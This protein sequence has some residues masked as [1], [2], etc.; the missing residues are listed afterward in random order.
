MT[1]FLNVAPGK[2]ATDI[3][4]LSRSSGGNRFDFSFTQYIYCIF[5]FIISFF[6]NIKNIKYRIKIVYCIRISKMI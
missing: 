5:I 3:I 1:E 6:G 4:I 2:A